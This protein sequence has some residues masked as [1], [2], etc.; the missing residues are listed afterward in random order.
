MTHDFALK[1]SRRSAA[2]ILAAGAGIAFTFTHPAIALEMIPVP[3]PVETEKESSGISPLEQRLMQ[4]GLLNVRTLDQSIMVDLKYARTDNFMGTN[5][6]GDF[7]HAY[8]R[9]E[10]ALKLVKANKILQER[11][12]NLRILVADACRPR[13]IQHKMWKHVVDTPMQPY[14]ANPDSGSLHNYGGAVDVTLYDVEAGEQL[15]MGTPLDFFGPLAQPRLETKFL[16]EGKLSEEQIKNR[17]ILRKAMVDAGWH[18]L[19][20][21]W[22]HFNAF[23]RDHIQRNYSIIE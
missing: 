2:F 18:V 4:K 19:Q 9:P 16:R 7:T 23:S 5:V 6:Y 3:A 10:A 11:H 22:W 8:L 14:V 15:D 12:P 21:E 13:S 1:C 17:R 20:I